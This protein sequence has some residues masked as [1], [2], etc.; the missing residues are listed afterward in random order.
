MGNNWIIDVLDD[1][2]VFARLNDLPSFAG[3]L[4]AARAAAIDDIAARRRAGQG[5]THPAR[6][7]AATFAANARARPGP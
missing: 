2:Q 3:Q 4:E 7:D 1:L 6:D 5:A